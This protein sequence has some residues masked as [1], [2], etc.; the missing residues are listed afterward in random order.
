M[1]TFIHFVYFHLFSVHFCAGL[2]KVSRMMLNATISK[3]PLSLFELNVMNKVRYLGHVIR[4]YLPNKPTV[5][6]F[7][8]CSSFGVCGGDT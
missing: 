7:T 8:L 2:Q 4:N 5:L 1:I 3:L 6:C